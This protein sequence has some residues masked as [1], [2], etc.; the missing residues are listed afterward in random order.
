MNQIEKILN[1]LD[2]KKETKKKLHDQFHDQV[3]G[4]FGTVVLPALRET[5]EALLKRGYECTVVEEVT[6]DLH[7]RYQE[8]ALEMHENNTLK[9]LLTFAPDE[10]NA[11]I[12]ISLLLGKDK[13]QKHVYKLDELTKE[14]VVEETASFLAGYF[15]M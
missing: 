12:V 15:D 1:K 11:E 9:A 8:V 13:V 10:G 4:F 3:T 6:A 7:F 14:K 5:K 2:E